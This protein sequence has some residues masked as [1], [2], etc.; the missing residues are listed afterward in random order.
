[1][2][3]ETFIAQFVATFCACRAAKHYEDYCA[4]DMHEELANAPLEDALFLAE[5]AWAKYVTEFLEKKKA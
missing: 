1:M 5:A 2:E 4:R 3:R